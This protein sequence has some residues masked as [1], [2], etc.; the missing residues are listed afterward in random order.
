MWVINQIIWTWK[1]LIRS[2]YRDILFASW[3]SELKRILDAKVSICFPLNFIAPHST[4][5]KMEKQFETISL[6]C[7]AVSSNLSKTKTL[8]RYEFL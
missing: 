1:N 7:I 5:S 3:E 6:T 4:S 2:S 8:L